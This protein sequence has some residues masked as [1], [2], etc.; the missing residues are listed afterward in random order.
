MGMRRLLNLAAFVFLLVSL[1]A[2]AQRGG[3]HGGFGGHASF[4]GG[5][6]GGGHFGGFS[7]R[8]FGA[9]VGGG[10]FYG[11]MR[12]GVNRGPRY[13]FNRGPRNGFS[14]GPYLRNGYGRNGHNGYGRNGY[15][16]NYPGRFHSRGFHR[17]FDR[18]NCWGY[19]CWAGNFG[20]GWGYPWWGYYDPSFDWS[21]DDA[22]FDNDYND[23]LALA[24][25]M[26][27]QSL[28]DQRMLRQEQQDQDQDVYAQRDPAPARRAPEAQPQQQ[29]EDT[30]PTVLIYRDQHKQEIQNYA[31]VGDNLWNFTGGGRRKIPLSELDIPATQKVNDD[32]GVSFTVPS[33]NQGQ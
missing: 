31:I 1:P 21:Y 20:Y 2:F 29:V 12:P 24:N 18:D 16:R 30:P 4:G 28:E 23:N 14:R 26:N 27:Q 32:R 33:A 17:R 3:G 19:G 10:H 7:G 25:Q 13:G 11:G 5:H 22:Q 15:G 9:H 8:S 6:F